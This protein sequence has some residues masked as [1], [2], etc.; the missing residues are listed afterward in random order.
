MESSG[1]SAVSGTTRA[2]L[3]DHRKYTYFP[4]W[5]LSV[6]AAVILIPSATTVIRLDTLLVTVDPA[7]V[8][9]LALVNATEEV[10]TRAPPIHHATA[11]ATIVDVRLLVEEVLDVTAMIA[12]MTVIAI[13]VVVAVTAD[14][15]EEIATIAAK[16]DVSMIGGTSN[17]MIVVIQEAV[18][19]KTLRICIDA[20]VLLT[21][22]EGAQDHLAQAPE[23]A[24][25]LPVMI[26]QIAKT[27]ALTKTVISN[28]LVKIVKLITSVPAV[29]ITLSDKIVHLLV[30]PTLVLL[31]VV[32]LP[33][34]RNPPRMEKINEL[35]LS[36]LVRVNT[37]TTDHKLSYM[38]HESTTPYYF[39]KQQT[40]CPLT[41]ILSTTPHQSSSSMLLV[42]CHSHPHQHPHSNSICLHSY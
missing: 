21:P 2:R 5:Y 33:E 6:I 39:D 28:L 3:A 13:D 35:P 16:I 42:Y 19:E 8:L 32:Q 1:A 26:R 31:P 29:K 30:V 9:A 20:E 40:F 37:A 41:N 17:V 11:I 15:K 24:G 7:A 14:M 36:P 25:A 22:L 4:E 34:K 10:E 38:Q 18:N 27:R 23:M 12:V